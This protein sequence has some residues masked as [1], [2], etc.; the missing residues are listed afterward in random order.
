MVA[1]VKDILRNPWVKFA[2]GCVLIP[3]ALVLLVWGLYAAQNIVTFI[4]IS[5]VIAYVLNPVVTRLEDYRIPRWLSSPVLVGGLI[6]VLL[7]GL[8]LVVWDIQKQVGRAIA[9][10]SASSEQSESTPEEGEP[11]PEPS[12]PPAAAEP[13][14]QPEALGLQEEAK[15]PQESSPPQDGGIPEPQPQARQGDGGDDA[16]ADEAAPGTKEWVDE[17]ILKLVQHLPERFRPVARR[18]AESIYEYVIPRLQQL[19]EGVGQVITSG[20]K[21]IGSVVVAIFL[22]SLSLVLAVYMLIHAPMLKSLTVS[23]LPASY[24]LDI[25][26]IAGKI[27][28]DVRGFIRGQLLVALS[29]AAIYMIGL[30]ILGIPY[31]A[32]IAIIGGLGNLIP[33]VGTAIGILL[34][35][36]SSL[37][38]HGFDINIL[39]VLV[40]FAAGQ[41]MEAMVIT[42]KLVGRTVKMNPVA[43]IIAV[44]IFGK[45]FGFFGALFAVPMASVIKV[46]GRELLQRIQQPG[47]IKLPP[48]TSSSPPP[49]QPEETPDQ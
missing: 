27:D 24:K 19:F 44:L 35:E 49:D 36:V 42:P 16:N 3:A 41:A 12:A 1:T 21:S 18:L 15:P 28:T 23:V 7:L 5:V 31:A 34:A 2:F 22:F 32:P 47:E 40:V 4:I 9:N 11:Q 33:Y 39:L 45:L 43:I 25:M 6:V 30:T 37:F 38:A 26:R 48:S 14:P 17:Q 10:N 46:L 13:E 20:L 8:F 29:L